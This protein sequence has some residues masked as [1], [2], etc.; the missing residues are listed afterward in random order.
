MHMKL[1]ALTLLLAAPAMAEDNEPYFTPEEIESLAPERCRGMVE[2]SSGPFTFGDSYAAAG[3]RTPPAFKPLIK[4]VTI[5]TTGAFLIDKCE[6]TQ[7]Q[8]HATWMM[9]FGK[10][11]GELNPKDPEAEHPQVTMNLKYAE[12]FCKYLGKRLPTEE[13]WEKAAR[14]G[15]STIYYW[16]DVYDDGQVYEQ[17]TSKFNL[18]RLTGPVAE[19]LP[20]PYGLYD[21]LGNAPEMTSGS[22]WKGGGRMLWSEYYA[23]VGRCA[24]PAEPG[25]PHNYGWRCVK[26]VVPNKSVKKDTEPQ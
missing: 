21:M 10:S 25:R 1:L 6:V 14:G 9:A 26:D 3:R 2:I 17:S 13:E 24:K 16:G 4:P 8:A 7:L 15:T 20:N 22:C 12:T 5:K 11:A 18:R 19:K 23:A